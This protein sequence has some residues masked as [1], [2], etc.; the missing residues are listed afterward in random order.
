MFSLF[1]FLLQDSNKRPL[2]I[3]FCTI[4]KSIMHK[5]FFNRFP[6]KCS[7][8]QTQFLK[9]QRIATSINFFFLYNSFL[10]HPCKMTLKLLLDI[11]CM[12]LLLRLLLL[13]LN[14]KEE[15]GVFNLTLHNKY[16]IMQ[17]YNNQC[18]TFVYLKTLQKHPSN[19][20]ELISMV[21]TYFNQIKNLKSNITKSNFLD[22]EYFFLH[23]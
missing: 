10:F 8:L 19:I 13:R 2:M 22:S 12:F 5:L 23:D 18:S 20:N 9:A 16:I 7:I 14:K 3:F 11:S 15:E 6:N 4:K 17:K 1:L 21:K